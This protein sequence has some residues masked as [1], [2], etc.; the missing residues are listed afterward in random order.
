MVAARQIDPGS[1]EPLPPGAEGELVLTTLTK[2]GFPLLR[3]RTRDITR[4]D[5]TPCPCGR[6]HWRMAR[7]TGR[8]DDML[9]IRGVNVYPSQIEA[10]LVETPGLSP[11]YQIQI[12]RVDNLDQ[13]EVLVELDEGFLQTDEV[14]RLESLTRDLARRIKDF[15]GVSALVRLVSPR[16]IG[17]SEGKALRVIDRRK[18]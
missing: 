4:L 14:R 12:D 2:E 10:L 3:Y 15:L 1:G 17:R 8:S 16:S 18:A 5:P 7:V 11:H 6:T 9:I 13:M